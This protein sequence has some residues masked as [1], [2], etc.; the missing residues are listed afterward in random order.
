MP[1]PSSRRRTHHSKP[2]SL[3]ASLS[4]SLLLISSPTA[5][6][7]SPYPVGGF[8]ICQTASALHIQGGVTYEPTATYLQPT[9]QHFRLD[10][11]QSFGLSSS[12][13]VW[14]NLTSD[15]SPYQRFHS[16]ACVPGQKKF[17]T[18]G[19][20]DTAN[21]GGAGF[22][23]AYDMDKGTWDAVEKAVSQ[24]TGPTGNG[25][26]NGNGKG[27]N[28]GGPRISAAGRTMAGF[29]LAVNPTTGSPI[30]STSDTAL[31]VVIGGGWIPQKSST[32]P[33]VL[34]SDLIGL[35]TEADLISINKSGDVD[36]STFVWTVAP[37][38]GNGG[39]NVNANLG[40][41]VGARVVIA[42]GGGKAVVVGGVV[43]GGNAGAGSGM[44][45]G[46]LPVVDMA[47][48][49]VISQKTISATPNGTPAPRYGHCVALST[50]GNTMYMFGGALAANDMITNDIFALDLTTWT[51]SQP[52]IAAGA[53]TPPPVRDH[54]CIMVGDQLLSLLGFNTNG[55]PASATPLALNATGTDSP[56][57]PSPPIYVLSTS[58]WSWST[59]F[60]ALPGTPRPPSP[61]SVSTDGSKGKVNGVAIGFGVVFGLA[62][63][64]VIGFQVFSHRRRKQRKADTLLLI[65]MEQRKKD[66][67]KLEK[68]RRKKDESSPLPAPP[69]P[70]PA[71]L[72]GGL[73]GGYEQDYYSQGGQGGG[74]GGYYPGG[75][76]P[77]QNPDYQ[78]QQ[79][80]HMQHMQHSQYGQ[81]TP[82]Q[83]Y[84]QPGAGGFANGHDRNPF[85]HPSG[86]PGNNLSNNNNNNSNNMYRSPPH[87]A[88]NPQ[89]YV[90]EEMG[91][92]A[93]HHA[94]QGGGQDGDSNVKVPVSRSGSGGELGVRGAGNK[95]SFVDSSSA[96]R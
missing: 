68:D 64:A 78:H 29:A 52:T 31:G 23:M 71:H 40:Q 30:P 80:M 14:A 55:A 95:M 24:D 69:Q 62:F 79:Q 86:T 81:F 18:V 21:A 13:P 35:V 89:L 7:S 66:D 91:S 77:F 51:W 45:L 38:G 53:I 26:N 88:S 5:T 33:S 32:T 42:P 94:G 2:L 20:A 96:Y 47:T 76:D 58:A 9:N 1:P 92:S 16:G 3:L 56:I 48:G 57:P 63:L 43:K 6:A 19:N 37:L 12:A 25:G 87:T 34:A 84:A 46:S 36:G 59:Q 49:A 70:Y 74:G 50:D 27:N 82:N 73:A 93:Y 8:A 15:F 22:M 4:L 10:L 90:P 54:Q 85:D 60:N 65:E 44:P 11:S 61:P 83:Y 17:L 41:V 67:E 75:H 39:Q 28:K 72:N